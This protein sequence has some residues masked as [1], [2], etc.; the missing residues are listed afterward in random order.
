[1]GMDGIEFW[2]DLEDALGINIPDEDVADLETLGQWHAYLVARLPH[3][4]PDQ[5]WQKQLD[6]VCRLLNLR[7]EQRARLK[8]TDHLVRDLG[9]S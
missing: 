1:M 8:P 5:I 3:V 9:F 7:S 2:M 6:V 4:S